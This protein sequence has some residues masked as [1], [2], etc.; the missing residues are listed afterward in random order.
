M[1]IK[2]LPLLLLLTTACTFQVQVL[3]TPV[4]LQPGSTA[5]TPSPLPSTPVVSRDVAA[6]ATPALMPTLSAANTPVPPPVTSPPDSV[7][8]IRFGPNGTYVDVLDSITAEN[9][10]TYSVNAMKGQIMSV[11]IH[12]NEQSEWTYITLR[13]VG[14]D[15]TLLCAEDCQYWRG[16]LPATQE[17]FVTVTPAAD[18]PDFTMRVAIN[19]PGEATQSFL[20]ENIYRNAS[21]TYTD[22]FAPAFFPTVL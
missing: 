14:A 8:P 16:V 9:S 2:L 20:Y 7:S 1:K 6:T 10:K 17:Y 22:L 15:H 18:A 13:I 5:T 19:P 11:S 4:A 12:Q 3:E 21:L